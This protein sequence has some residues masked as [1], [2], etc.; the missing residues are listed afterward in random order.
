MRLESIISGTKGLITKGLLMTSLAFSALGG[1]ATTS[2]D[3]KSPQITILELSDKVTEKKPVLMKVDVEDEDSSEVE[4]R[5]RTDA[6]GLSLEE[7]D[8]KKNS[9]QYHVIGDITNAAEGLNFYDLHIDAIDP[10]G[11]KTTEHQLI[12]HDCD[13]KNPKLFINAKLA[14]GYL[15][16]NDNSLPN[17]Y[18]SI[19]AK[20]TFS[21]KD[22]SVLYFYELE[23]VFSEDDNFLIR[24]SPAGV[25]GRD[26][27]RSNRIS[28]NMGFEY[29][30]HQGN[31]KPGLFMKLSG[32]E[33]YAGSIEA[34]DDLEYYATGTTYFNEEWST[35]VGAELF[36]RDIPKFGIITDIN[37]NHYTEN[38]DYLN[39]SFGAGIKYR[40]EVNDLFRIDLRT[41][42]VFDVFK[43]DKL[44]HLLLELMMEY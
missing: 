8:H 44:P 19:D 20:G 34:I 7:Y 2:E 38:K 42:G 10:S 37:L 5:I 1:C 17:H 3:I 26:K 18:F 28:F 11:N 27:F 14:Y 33:V 39:L 40:F 4:V 32:D 43:K 29:T 21:A 12:R 13:I 35:A 23:S 6:T 36:R 30:M 9:W 16:T 41:K 25:M 24:F 22:K 15:L 31:G